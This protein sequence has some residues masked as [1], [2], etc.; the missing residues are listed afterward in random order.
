MIRDATRSYFAQRAD[1]ERQCAAS[2]VHKELAASYDRLAHSA[3]HEAHELA[4]AGLQVAISSSG[5]GAEA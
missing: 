5:R 1:E 3:D 4:R 2:A